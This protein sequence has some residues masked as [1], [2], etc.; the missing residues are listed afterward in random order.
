[1]NVTNL[2]MEAHLRHTCW[3]PGTQTLGP[4]CKFFQKKAY[5]CQRKKSKT[6]FTPSNTWD[7]WYTGMTPQTQHQGTD[8]RKWECGWEKRKKRKGTRKLRLLQNSL[9][10]L[11][12]R[13]QLD[14]N[15]CL[16]CLCLGQIWHKSEHTSEIPSQSWSCSALFKEVK[17]DHAGKKLT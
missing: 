17:I 2:N 3:G 11:D 13:G 1:M 4:G 6:F 16:C 12:G 8:R 14:P 10:A 7:L 15:L 9:L 5:L